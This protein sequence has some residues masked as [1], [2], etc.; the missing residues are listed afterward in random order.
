MDNI[1][2]TTFINHILII[3]DTKIDRMTD[4]INSTITEVHFESNRCDTNVESDNNHSLSIDHIP[5]S[6]YSKTYYPNVRKVVVH[7]KPTKQE[8]Y[9]ILLA[10]RNVMHLSLIAGYTGTNFQIIED[11]ILLLCKNLREIDIHHVYENDV[12]NKLS[13]NNIKVNICVS[14]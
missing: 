11:Y 14:I 7:F 3:H 8:L 2:E 6:E 10:F 13:E 12:G 4:I 5:S 9:D 1:Q